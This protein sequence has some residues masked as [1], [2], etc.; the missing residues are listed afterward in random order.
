MQ[1]IVLKREFESKNN[2]SQIKVLP[3]FNLHVEEEKNKQTR[4]LF[5]LS[6]KTQCA[7]IRHS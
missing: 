2:C 5:Q 3:I 4:V 7:Y 6:C 1:G